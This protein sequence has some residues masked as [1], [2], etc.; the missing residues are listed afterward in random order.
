MEDLT[1]LESNYLQLARAQRTPDYLLQ[2]RIYDD[3]QR[4]QRKDWQLARSQSNQ[5]IVDAN[6]AKQQKLATAGQIGRSK[7]NNQILDDDDQLQEESAEWQPAISQHRHKYRV[8]Q[9]IDDDDDEK[10]QKEE[11][12]ENQINELQQI[13]HRQLQ[14]LQTRPVKPGNNDDNEDDEDDDDQ[15][16]S[17]LL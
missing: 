11:E 17:F 13:L 8:L 2:Q 6:E 14:Q 4:Q 16:R 1:R 12:S 5:Q 3:V 15:V 7:N 9:S 10:Y